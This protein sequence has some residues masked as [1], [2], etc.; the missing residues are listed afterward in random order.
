MADDGPQNV[1]RFLVLMLDSGTT[2]SG[3]AWAQTRKPEIQSPVIVWPD[4]T[5]GG[6]EGAT[7]DKVPTEIQ[8]SDDGYKWGFQIDDFGQRH[9]WFKLGLDP[10]QLRATS[11]LARQYPDPNAAPPAYGHSP[12]KLVKDYLTALRSH[13]E[14]VLRQ[15]LPQ[16]ALASTP[17][18]YVITVPA[19]WSDRAQ[20]ATR[21]CAEQAGMGTGSSLHI[22]SEP[23]A[24]AMYALDAMDPHNIQIGDTFVLCDAGGGT[25]DLISYKVSALKPVLRIQE[26]A[27]GSGSLCGSTFLNRI[28]QKFLE[29]RFKSDR[30]WDEDVL[31]EAMKRFEVTVKRSFSGNPNIEYQIPG[32]RLPGLKDNATHGVRRGRLRLTGLQV[33][34]IFE[35]VVKEIVALVNGQIDATKAQVK[36]VLMVGGFGQNVYLRDNIRQAIA[37]RNIEC[38][39]SPNGWTAVVRGA[40]MKG[41]TSTNS[42]FTAEMT[43]T[44]R[45]W[46]PFHGAHYIGVMIWFIT[47]GDLVEENKPKRLPFI[48][49]CP[50]SDGPPSSIDIQ[51]EMCADNDNQGQSVYNDARVHHLVTAT[52]DLRRIPAHRFPRTMGS[53]GHSYYRVEFAVEV[54]YCSAFTKY[55]LVHNNINYGSVAAE[56]V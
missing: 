44:G 25:V 51:I 6:L 8:Y 10:S 23:E 20:A 54:T 19:V 21:R 11:D 5:S 37:S 34:Q 39:Q 12:E 52:A 15:K 38:M 43:K 33:S 53:D 49:T 3:L 2:Y 32:K 46:Y 30:N 29:D 45:F 55:E 22:I 26:A 35:P 56:Y 7:S 1:E 27:P 47:K 41:L 24:A 31:E 16:S 42:T 18:E 50:V 4:A 48:R 17:V 36:A 28:F 13:A 40:L 14:R 9:Q